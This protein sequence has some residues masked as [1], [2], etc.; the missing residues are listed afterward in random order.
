MKTQPKV[1]CLKCPL[2]AGSKAGGERNGFHGGVDL[3]LVNPPAG[4]VSYEFSTMYPGTSTLVVRLMP[5]TYNLTVQ[6]TSGSLTQSITFPLAAI[7]P[8]DTST[9]KITV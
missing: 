8:P 6:G 2:N 9:R 5:G 7:A 3:T 1:S 4:V